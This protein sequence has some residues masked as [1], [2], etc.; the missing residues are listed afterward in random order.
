VAALGDTHRVTNPLRLEGVETL[1][2][3]VAARGD[4]LIT[5]VGLE[6]GGGRAPLLQVEARLRVLPASAPPAQAKVDL[7][8]RLTRGSW[9]RILIGPTVVLGIGAYQLARSPTSTGSFVLF[10]A[11]ACVIAGVGVLRAEAILDR[12][13]PGLREVAGLVASGS[14]HVPAA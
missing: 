11:V 4:Y 3:D 1:H 10:F 14:L 13:W 12:A 9:T 2:F 6:S 5:P 7:T 8:V